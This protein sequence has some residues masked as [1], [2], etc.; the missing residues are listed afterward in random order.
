V[1][2]GD[3]VRNIKV[4]ID[5]LRQVAVV[6]PDARTR[7]TAERG[8]DALGRGVVATSSDLAALAEPE[9]G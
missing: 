8:A 5:L 4:L 6:A 3:F 7:A 1:S 9:V 2:A